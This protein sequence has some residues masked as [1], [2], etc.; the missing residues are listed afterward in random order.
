[1]SNRRKILSVLALVASLSAVRAVDGQTVAFEQQLTGS[2]AGALFGRSVDVDGTMAIVGSPAENGV[3]GAAYVFRKVGGTWTPLQRLVASDGA[4]SANFG[5]DV[6]ISGNTIAIGAR[7][8]KV[9]ATGS[10]HGAA[11]VFVS[12]GSTWVEQAKLV[13]SDVS[14]NAQFG[15][16]VD[17]EGNTVVVGANNT[18]RP[19]GTQIGAAYVFERNGGSWVEQILAAPDGASFDFFGNS[20]G[21][22]GNT[23]CVGAIGDDVGTNDGQG[24]AYVFTRSGSTFSFQQKL[25]ASDG[26]AGDAFGGSCAID[27]D[28]IVI[29]AS[30]DDR[31]PAAN[32]GAAYV[33]VRS[34]ATWSQQQ[35]LTANDAAANDSFG[36]AAIHGD[37]AVVGA[38]GDESTRGSAYVYQRSGATWSQQQKLE[39]TGGVSGDQFGSGVSIDGSSVLIGA[40]ALST[41]SR[42]GTAT[43][44]ALTASQTGAP[45]APASFQA[46]AS[47]NTVNL[48]WAAPVSGGAPTGYTLIGRTTSGQ[49]LATVPLGNVTSMSAA[50]PDGAYALSVQASN[51]SG[52]GPE[53]A[54][55]TVTVPTTTPPPGNPTNL[56]VSVASNAATF[57]WG[58]P[59]SGGPATGYLFAAGTSPSFAVPLAVVPLPAAPRSFSVTGIPP[60]TFYVRLLAQNAGGTSGASNEVTLSVAGALA[61][62]APTLNAPTVS[63]TTVGL[64]WSAGGGGAPTSYVIAAASSPGGAPFTTATFGGTSISIPGVPRGTYFLRLVAV[65]AAGT[66]AASNEITLVVP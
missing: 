60:G 62:G 26:A 54:A 42:P 34:G 52:T 12:N 32:Q 55:V 23:L 41:G 24:S 6:A 58:A 4:P 47:G 45:G 15:W 13:A 48:S 16:T 22:S 36:V 21:I 37:V 50:A 66:S 53:S 11:Y 35:K 43:V 20:I 7:T 14:S 46:V 51:A 65:N 17:V 33:F 8:A 40:P 59:T 1:M 2:A 30:S 27:A 49:M 25:A 38:L 57:T 56:V 63:G 19:S 28:T 29:A 18:S 31:G 61:P 64:S 39:P 44:Y 10:S 9:G 5:T 3:Q